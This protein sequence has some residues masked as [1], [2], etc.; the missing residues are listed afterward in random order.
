MKFTG[1]IEKVTAVEKGVSSNN[2]PW[3]S[4]QIVACFVNESG[5]TER[6]LLSC[7]NAAC[8]KAQV[9]V[10]KYAKSD[11]SFAGEC[12]FYFTPT[13]RSYEDRNWR[14]RFSQELML[15]HVVE[16]GR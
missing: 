1:K 9:L 8:E 2:F 5:L 14:Q 3:Q 12:E 15:N 10:D 4:C 13:V 6:V 7:L 11:G 16:S